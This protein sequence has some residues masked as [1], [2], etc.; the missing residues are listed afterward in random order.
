VTAIAAYPAGRAA[1]D[2]FVLDRRGPRPVH[3]SW[4][5]P[6]VVVDPEPDG[7]GRRVDVATVFL[8]GRECPWHCAMCD[9]WQHTIAEDTPAGAIA[10]QVETAVGT[11]DPSVRAIKLY[12]AGSYFDPRAVPPADDLRVARRVGAARCDRVVVES[13]PALI[14]D[15]CWAFRDRVAALDV[16]IGL[17]TVHPGALEA[18]NKGITVD[19]VDAAAAALRAH[20]VGL[21]VFLLV[22]PPFVPRHEQTAWLERSVDAAIE[23]GAGVISL[24]PTRGGNGTLEALAADGQFT[25]P[26]IADLEGAAA[27][28]IR[29]AAA[30]AVVLADLW[31]IDGFAS[32]PA[33]VTPRRDRLLRLNL[34][35]R[36][37]EA[38]ACAACGAVTPA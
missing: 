14:G 34:D 7:H 31:D 33:C 12:N 28:A 25:P 18:I 36:V 32:C 1:R 3:D 8:T 17:E 37:P 24:I 30:R 5:P 26:A 9:L 23:A 35:Q 27:A 11:L 16:A 22:H 29:R 2:R 20:D 19:G 38:V 6:R 21:R 10:R 13:H 15:R 4:A